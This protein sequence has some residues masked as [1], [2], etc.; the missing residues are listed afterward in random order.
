MAN[1]V[2][3]IAPCWGR[4]C[5]RR[6]DYVFEP[7]DVGESDGDG[8]EDGV[9]PIAVCVVQA[10]HVTAAAT[11]P[12]R[13]SRLGSTTGIRSERHHATVHSGGGSL[14]GLLLPANRDPPVSQEPHRLAVTQIG[15]SR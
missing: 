9:R 11:A 12:C 13:F 3:T 15:R 6:F 4:T 2:R 8:Q 10:T 7:L 1:D 5:L 14:G